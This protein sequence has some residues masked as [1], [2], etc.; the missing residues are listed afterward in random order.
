MSILRGAG[1]A[2]FLGGQAPPNNAEQKL[3]DFITTVVPSA[4]VL[5]VVQGEI[6]AGNQQSNVALTGSSPFQVWMIARAETRQVSLNGAS[7]R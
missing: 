2:Q 5:K 4:K 6:S 1:V 3:P 7:P